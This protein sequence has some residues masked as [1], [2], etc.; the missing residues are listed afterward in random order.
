M[1]SRDEILASLR[2]AA[3]D[4]ASIAPSNARGE[5]EWLLLHALGSSLK[6]WHRAGPD[7][8][9]PDAH[10]ARFE[11]LLARRLCHEPLQYIVGHA[12]FHDLTLDV[13]PGVLVPRPETEY[14]VDLLFQR[15]DP[16]RSIAAQ[17]PPR[18]IVDVGTGSGA[19]LFALLARFPAARGLGIDLSPEALRWACRNRERLRGDV[20]PALR[21]IGERSMLI[22]CDL[23]EALAPGHA[24]V[25]VANLPYISSATIAALDPEVRDHEPRGALD[26][27]EDGLDLV[28]RLLP[29][30]GSVIAPG[31]WVLFEL[32]V[33]QPPDIARALAADATIESVEVLEDLTRRPRGILA[34]RLP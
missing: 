2:Q 19:M 32:D 31:G 23:T 22:R 5:A 28:R 8:T 29:A 30:L 25:L 20:D 14:L 11:A 6:E 18:W 3:I 16:A 27:G 7:Q 34:R 33:A 26:G 12:S 24:D 4:L 21:S 15:L 17:E 1:W 10:R 9:W 13:G